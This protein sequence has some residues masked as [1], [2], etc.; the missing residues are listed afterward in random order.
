MERPATGASEIVAVGSAVLD[1]VYSLSNLPEPDGGAFVRDHEERWGGVAANV[2]CGLS[3]LDHEVAIIS[4]VGR[5]EAGTTILESLRAWDVDVTPVRRGDEASS[6]TLVLRSPTGDRMIVAGGESIPALRIC[7]EDRARLESAAC[8]FTSA[9]APDP[10]TATLMTMRRLGEIDCLVFDL[11]GPLAEL[12]GR[13]TAPATIDE[14]AAVADLFVSN[15]VAVE[16]YLDVEPESAV[17]RLSNAG[18]DRVAVTMGADGAFLGADDAEI[19]H[20]P[21]DER[22]IVDTTGAGDQFTA[23]LIHTWVLGDA[24]PSEAGRVA[25]RAAAQNCTAPGPRGA[26]ASNDDLEPIG[27]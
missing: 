3:A 10:V 9:Y 7:P 12:E 15:R 20:V 5:D 18:A 4:R 21:A 2:A 14:A 8:V 11:P 19:V 17:K 6:Y 23:A 27:D 1:R 22:Q 13:G 26:L 16:S 25:A 24:T